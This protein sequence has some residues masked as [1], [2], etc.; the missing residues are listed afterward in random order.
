MFS[1]V[2]LKKN[3]FQRAKDCW[4]FVMEVRSLEATE[5]KSLRKVTIDG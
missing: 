1:K 3:F 4:K 2:G 5:D